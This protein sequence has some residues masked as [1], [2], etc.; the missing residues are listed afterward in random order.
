MGSSVKDTELKPMMK[1]KYAGMLVFQRAADGA[2]AADTGL[3]EWAS[4]GDP[5]GRFGG[6][7][8]AAA[9]K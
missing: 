4:E 8:T 5:N 1:S 7:I 2:M 3:A 6:L 9:A